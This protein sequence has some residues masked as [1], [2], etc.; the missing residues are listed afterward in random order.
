MYE[1][2]V[3]KNKE[4]TKKSTQKKVGTK[5]KFTGSYTVGGKPNKRESKRERWT[6]LHDEVVTI[7]FFFVYLNNFPITPYVVA[8]KRAV[9]R[10]YS[11]FAVAATTVAPKQLT[12]ANERS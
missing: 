8:F 11:L 3:T 1:S 10:L 12:P 5:R 7:I 6:D 2:V 4:K 9:F